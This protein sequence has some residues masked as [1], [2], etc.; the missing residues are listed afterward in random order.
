MIGL[1]AATARGRAMA[2][3][4]ERAWGDARVFAGNPRE[5][6]TRAWPACE[7]LVLF[8]AVGAAV[9]LVAPLL[10]GK[11]RDPGVVA[12]DDGT[13]FAVAIV[14]GH[15][16]GANALARRVADALGAE[17]VITTASDVLGIPAVGS[18]GAD[19]GFQLDPVSDVAGV[20]AALLSG[21]R[22][23]LV[24][25]Q[26]WP[27]PALP[28]GLE[29]SARR[30]PPCILV[31]DRIVE[32]VVR[33]VVLRPP[34]LVV[35]VGCSRGTSAEEV[36]ALVDGVL[37][38]AGLSPL[39]VAELR[40]I[41]A[42]RDEEG[43]REAAASRG[44]PLSLFPPHRLRDVPVPNPSPAV[45]Q[46]VATLSVAE[47]A[48]VLDGAELVVPKRRSARVTVAVARR[49]PWGRLAIVGT[50]PGDPSLVPPMA[51]DALA[52]AEVVVGMDAY[53]ERIRPL[54]RPG[55]VVRTSGVGAE[56]T[57]ARLAVEEAAGGRSVALV[58]G[59]D[60][61]IYGMAPEALEL[62]QPGIDVVCVPGITA[63]L[64]AASL[65][66]APLGHDHCVISLSD[67]QTPWSVIRSRIR[68]AAE[69][70]LVVVLYNPRSGRRGW[71]L[72]ETRRI[73]LGHRDPET[74]VGVVADAFRPGQRVEI[75][76]LG[77]FDAGGAGMT[78]TVVVGCSR[79]RIVHGRMVTPRRY[80]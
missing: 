72:E 57:R 71:Q 37:S 9:R 79:T 53:V 52:R 7:G 33:T 24:E 64:A 15:G 55:T 69:A 41:D 58:S 8:M 22:V 66:G 70:D 73:L 78:T 80:A 51:R 67:L 77:R 49:R 26:R 46:A 23:R 43:L 39:S 10:A 16:G 42:K 61:G 36:L 13:R 17:P 40:S 34:S 45:A 5:A 62:V 6:L 4:L 12:V 56:R 1:V 27:L 60:A 54:L 32:R 38:E 11:G 3:H 76:T 63:A 18:L 20:G 74:P 48:A 65:L 31:T 19:L 30:E 47:A 68:A 35:G 14:G 28:L 25:D 29:R 21:E 44:W 75:T 2:R 59:G 50:G